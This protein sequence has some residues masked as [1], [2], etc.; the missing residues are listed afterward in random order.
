MAVNA[1]C[2]GLLGWLFGHKLQGVW[3]E[4][5]ETVPWDGPFWF[6]SVEGANPPMNREVRTYHGHV[7]LRCGQ[8]VKL[9]GP[10]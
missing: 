1:G 8:S 6:R 9:E 7:C 2:D 4:E 10:G 3:S 5:S